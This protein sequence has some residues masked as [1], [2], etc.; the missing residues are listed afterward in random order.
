MRKPQTFRPWQPE[1]TSMLPPSPSD[2]LSDDHQVYV[3]LDQVY[4][5]DLCKIL[6]H[7]QSKDPGG[8]Q[9]FDSRMMTLLLVYAYRVGIVS[10]RKIKRTCY[11][12]LTFR[13]LTANQHPVYSGSRDSLELLNRKLAD[14]E[15]WY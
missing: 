7:S 6:I 10:S 12:V 2:W 13:M 4:E 14:P 3:L 5:L 9:G 11:R 8:E 1:Q 15:T